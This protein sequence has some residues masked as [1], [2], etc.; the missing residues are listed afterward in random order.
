[1]GNPRGQLNNQLL[2]LMTTMQNSALEKSPP[3]SAPR[4]SKLSPASNRHRAQ[5]ATVGP[6]GTAGTGEAL[7]KLS[8]HG[9]VYDPGTQGVGAG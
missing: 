7:G 2:A 3:L 4:V 1:M 8:E 6:M 9:L 5:A